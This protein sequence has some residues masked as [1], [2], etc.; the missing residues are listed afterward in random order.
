MVN[1]NPPVGHAGVC[2]SMSTLV[3]KS[4]FLARFSSDFSCHDVV[5]PAIGILSVPDGGVRAVT[6]PS[7]V[8]V[9]VLGISNLMKPRSVGV[10][11]T[12]RRLPHTDLRMIFDTPKEDE[13]VPRFGPV[14]YTHLTLPT[15]LLV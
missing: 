4:D 10:N 15:I 7:L 14:S 6:S 12:D 9:G 8:E 13:F 11:D 1:Q 3:G 5:A 2:P